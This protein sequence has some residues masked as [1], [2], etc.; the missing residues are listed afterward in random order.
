MKETRYKIL[1]AA[2]FT[3]VVMAVLWGSNAIYVVTRYLADSK[4]YDTVL[5]NRD[6]AV[7]NVLRNGPAYL[8]KAQTDETL[9][10]VIRRALSDV[11]VLRDGKPAIEKLPKGVE[12]ADLEEAYKTPKVFATLDG[13]RAKRSRL[14][15]G[16]YQYEIYSVVAFPR[17]TASLLTEFG[18]FALATLPAMLVVFLLAWL[19]VARSLA[20]VEGHMKRLEEFSSDVSHELRTPIAVIRS[21]MELAARTGDWQDAAVEVKDAALR[22]EKTVFSLLRLAT[23]ARW[24]DDVKDADLAAEVRDAARRLEL[25]PP[26]P[27]LKAVCD[28]SGAWP[29]Y[30]VAAD[31]WRICLDNFLS[32]AAKYAE[33]KVTVRLSAGELSVEDDGPG[34]AP[35][36]IKKIFD[37]YWQERKDGGKYGGYGVGLA[38]VRK[39]CELQD[40]EVGARNLPQ[41]GTAFYMKFDR[42]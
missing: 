27:G 20:P 33:G 35:D 11:L 4:A 36:K 18:W 42:D 16:G 1:L 2:A 29:S 25:A 7:R 32:N 28:V 14:E 10:K 31:H 22:M 13:W 3:L 12:Q 37:R 9:A 34:I 26:K 5:D 23:L 39:I 41:G 19:F 24:F 30:R 38:I 15:M 8:D 40:W 17:G 21:S 6:E